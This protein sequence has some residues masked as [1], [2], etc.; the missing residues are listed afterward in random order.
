MIAAH[1]TLLE[2]QAAKFRKIEEDQ[3]NE[4]QRLLKIQLMKADEEMKHKRIVEKHMEIQMA[5]DNMKKQ[6]STRGMNA[7]G[8]PS[9]VGGSPL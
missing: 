8:S 9:I 6:L 2:I 1:C 7:S 5:N 4:L 3:F